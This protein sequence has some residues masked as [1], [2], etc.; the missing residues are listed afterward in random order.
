MADGAKKSLESTQSNVHWGS[1]P[2]HVMQDE[3]QIHTKWHKLRLKSMPKDAEWCSDS[4]KMTQ[5]EGC[6]IHAKWQ[7][8]WLSSMPNE[9]G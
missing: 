1:H 8:L 5:T 4:H 6:W 2:H 3:A 7:T 9:T